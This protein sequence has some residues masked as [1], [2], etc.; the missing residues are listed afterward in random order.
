MCTHIACAPP[1]RHSSGR[2]TQK[3]GDGEGLD[4]AVFVCSY[5][6]EMARVMCV[7]HATIVA[8]RPFWVQ[9]SFSAI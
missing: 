6:M 1:D 7:R 5:L 2:S 9:F 3:A 4:V 8:V